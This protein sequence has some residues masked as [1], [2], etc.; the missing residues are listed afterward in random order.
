MWGS[1]F[2]LFKGTQSEIFE[3]GIF[4]TGKY[5]HIPTYINIFQ[6]EEISKLYRVATCKQ[7]EK[8]MFMMPIVL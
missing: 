5:G 4:I 6:G 7:P 8:T 1:K 2:T 3:N